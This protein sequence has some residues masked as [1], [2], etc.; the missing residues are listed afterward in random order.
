MPSLTVAGGWEEDEGL[1]ANAQGQLAGI[2]SE[3]GKL[4]LDLLENGVLFAGCFD[5][6]GAF[7][8]HQ[9][10]AK[11]MGNNCSAGEEAVAPTVIGMVVGIND[12]AHRHVQLFFDKVPHGEGFF[13]QCQ[14]INQHSP[15]RASDGAG[16]NLGI[17]FTL[18]PIY[19]VRHALALHKTILSY[20]IAV[21]ILPGIFL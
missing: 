18:K 21:K 15:L 11:G 9:V 2:K 17:N 8:H 14:G 19:I 6:D 4:E 7:F 12:I 20:E 16:G 5:G 10:A 1:F 3:M 13:R